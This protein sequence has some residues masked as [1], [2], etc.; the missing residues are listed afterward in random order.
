MKNWVIAIVS[1]ILAWATF[2]GLLWLWYCAIRSF[3]PVA[4]VVPFAVV[5]IVATA[6]AIHLE[7]ED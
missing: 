5:L 7:Q 1:S 3:G 2:V 6:Y 4:I